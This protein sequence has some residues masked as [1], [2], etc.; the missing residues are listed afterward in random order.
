V[1]LVRART[2]NSSGDDIFQAD[3]HLTQRMLEGD[4]RAFEEFFDANFDRVYRFAV[5]RV[6]DESAAED[7]AQATL[8]TGIR[9]LQTWRGEAALF[10]WLCAICRREVM[11]HVERTKSAASRSLSE[12]DPR[13]VAPL[14]QIAASEWNPEEAAHHRE[15]AR[16][17]Q[18]TLD[19]L[20]GRY[21]DL[22]EWKYLHGLTVTEI[23]ERLGQSG[24]AVESMLTRARAAFREGF[25]SLSGSWEAP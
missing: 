11:A 23:A 9:K 2:A 16:R 24:K 20:P 1:E 18:F 13:A 22:L 5:R 15:I 21:G 14:D 8:V 4:E 19:D 3:R 7:I 10:T 17:V 6:G 12:D 25:T